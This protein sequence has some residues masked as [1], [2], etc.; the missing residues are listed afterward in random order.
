MLPVCRTHIENV[1][2]KVVNNKTGD[3]TPN[4]F[5]EILVRLSLNKYKE[6]KNATTA[7]DKL[8]KLLDEVEDKVGVADINSFGKLLASQK[9]PAARA[10]CSTLPPEMQDPLG[11]LQ[12]GAVPGGQGGVQQK[13]GRLTPPPPRRGSPPP[14]PPVPIRQSVRSSHSLPFCNGPSQP[15]FQATVTAANRFAN[16]LQPHS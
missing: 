2:A 10:H 3:I 1:I 8:G 4:H 15:H 11:C 5:T 7:A 13:V 6:E 9:V 16:L 12:P 14:L